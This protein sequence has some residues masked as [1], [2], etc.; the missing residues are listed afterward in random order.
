MHTENTICFIALSSLVAFQTTIAGC[1]LSLE[2]SDVLDEKGIVRSLTAAYLLH[3][4]TLGREEEGHS[5][6]QLLI[7]TT[8]YLDFF[9][10]EGSPEK[11][12]DSQVLSDDT[13][14][15]K[16]TPNGPVVSAPLP[17]F[18]L[19][20]RRIAIEIL[21]H[22]DSLSE[23]NRVLGLGVPDTTLA[24][25][26]NLAK[27]DDEDEPLMTPE[28]FVE[29]VEI[30]DESLGY[31]EA[32]YEAIYEETDDVLTF[33]ED[34]Y[35]SV[36]DELARIALE[37]SLQGFSDVFETAA[38]GTMD[39]VCDTFL[40]VRESFRGV[41]LGAAAESVWNQFECVFDYSGNVGEDIA[42]SLRTGAAD[43]VDFPSDS[44]HPYCLP[45]GFASGYDAYWNGASID[46][47]FPP[48]TLSAWA[49]EYLSPPQPHRLTTP[50]P[51][52]QP[53]V[54]PPEG[55]PL[56]E[57]EIEGTVRI[58]IPIPEGGPYYARLQVRVPS[59]HPPRILINGFEPIHCTCNDPYTIYCGDC[60]Y[61]SD[62]WE[63]TIG[64]FYSSGENNY[65]GPACLDHIFDLPGNST[66]TF[67]H[68]A[69]AESVYWGIDLKYCTECGYYTN[70]LEN[71][72]WTDSNQWPNWEHVCLNC[73]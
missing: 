3:P 5:Y 10:A 18:M 49:P 67:V 63:G 46:E 32:I 50:N 57:G 38:T 55:E 72:I 14:R 29:A 12:M 47:A 15:A 60:G 34:F 2:N 61:M 59:L 65:I 26:S 13:Q 35:R 31:G 11:L 58:V 23:A 24:L 28:E 7:L 17:D 51:Y 4:E 43:L 56:S 73:P 71:E 45:A 44:F 54:V 36:E 9:G 37:Q 64:R 1:A 53:P 6:L 19:E 33:M 25:F 16:A 70:C 42:Y 69:T 41:S 27:Q 48:E 52:Y 66:V 20:A 40:N 30:V 22:G 39:F 8:M 68:E 21:D 62:E